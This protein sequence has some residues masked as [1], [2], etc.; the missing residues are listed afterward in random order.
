MDLIFFTDSSCDKFTKILHP[1]SSEVPHLLLMQ[2][3]PAYV[4]QADNPS[5]S[6]NSSPPDKRP[7]NPVLLQP[8]CCNAPDDRSE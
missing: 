3:L 5:A 4:L 2:G 8:E 6:D 1:L 7:H